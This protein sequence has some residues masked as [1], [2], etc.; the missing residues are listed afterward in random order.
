M[1]RRSGRCCLSEAHSP[2][3]ITRR[4][5][6]GKNGLGPHLSDTRRLEGMYL[7]WNRFLQRDV[8]LISRQWMGARLS[9]LLPTKGT[10]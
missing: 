1:H 8:T 4:W 7:S 5:V 9:M 2:L 3:S 6:K 10:H